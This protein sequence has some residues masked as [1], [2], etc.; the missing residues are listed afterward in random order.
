M[1]SFMAALLTGYYDRVYYKTKAW[2]EDYTVSLENY[3]EAREKLEEFLD[4]FVTSD[5]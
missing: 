3:G 4:R 1:E 5:E 2:K